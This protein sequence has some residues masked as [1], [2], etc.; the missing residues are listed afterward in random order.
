MYV[1]P[2][3]SVVFL[4]LSSPLSVT[5][6]RSTC[7]RLG[8]TST[9][10][11]SLLSSSYAGPTAERYGD[12]LC[13]VDSFAD[14]YVNPKVEIRPSSRQGGFGAF[15]ARDIERDELLFSIPR[16]A[17]VTVSDATSDPDCGEALKNLLKKA[18]PGGTTVALAGY[19]AKEYL[20][21]KELEKKT[22]GSGSVADSALSEQFD[23]IKFAPYI[24]TLPWERGVNDQE[25]VLFWTEAD[26]DQ[27]LKGSLSY[28]ESAELRN[29]VKLAVKVLNGLV[30]PTIRKV[31]GE[32]TINPLWTLLPWEKD[33]ATTSSTADGLEEAVVGAFV[34][35]LTRSFTT[36][37]F[38]ERLVPLLDMLQHSD[39]PSVSHAS[40]DGGG[41][42]VRAKV[43][44]KAN[45]EI[46]NRYQK[47]TDEDE[48]RMPRH[49]FFT[50]FGFVPGSTT[51]VRQMLA[52]RNELFYP[53]QREV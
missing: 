25:H 9:S 45:E 11:D 20:K 1:P 12:L 19:L 37:V 28:A 7:T 8:G 5:R 17:C 24:R 6:T 46:F 22:T 42:E 33:T 39:T 31:R 10:S 49:R 51:P 30:G 44:I 38:E 27:Y 2:L 40:N 3:F 21:M 18:G 29:E 36:D 34:T 32:K 13:W 41:V 47:E 16:D 4:S 26:V 23:D 48:G 43:E 15:A 50:R 14:S 35:I 52:E 53:K